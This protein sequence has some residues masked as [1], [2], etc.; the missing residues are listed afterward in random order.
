MLF[1]L[2]NPQEALRLS[3]FPRTICGRFH[4][5]IHDPSK[6]IGTEGFQRRESR[7]IRAGDLLPQFAG[8][9]APRKEQ[10]GRSGNSMGSKVLGDHWLESLLN[11]SGD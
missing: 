5:A 6:P 9:I 2:V 7:P 11:A 3:Q 8:R 4:S 10:L 1:N